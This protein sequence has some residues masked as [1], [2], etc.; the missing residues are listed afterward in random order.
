MRNKAK[1]SG[2]NAK[3]AA[4]RPP[5][6]ERR[7]WDDFEVLL[8]L[9]RAG[10]LSGAAQRLGV[11]AST[12]GRRLDALESALGVHLFDR[13]PTGIAPTDTAEALMPIAEAMER[14][15]ADA[16]RLVEGRETEPEGLV[17]ITAPPGLA[18]WFLAPALVRLRARHPKLVIELA[19]SVSYADLTRREADI[20]LRGKR[21]RTGD[22]V[23]VRLAEAAS[24][25]VAGPTVVE[26]LGEL[27][28]LDA[29]DWITW[30]P[31]LA[32]F[33]DAAWVT[34]NVDPGHIV[35]RTSSMDAQIHAAKVGLGAMLLTRPFLAWIDLRELPLSRSLA[36]RL[37]PT[38]V[39]SLWMVGHRALRTVPRIAAVWDFILEEAK[40]FG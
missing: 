4:Q 17:R 1:R 32:S 12:V 23:A 20:A 27:D 6:G 3:Q 35:L 16:W 38:P 14:S 26:R 5:S 29:V 9:G 18:N 25:V 37:P 13:A 36:R 39:G 2:K 8:A 34:A 11:N 22:F 21:P 31:D 19:A 10:T 33:P 30:G 40:R 24:I 15:I 28:R 7:G